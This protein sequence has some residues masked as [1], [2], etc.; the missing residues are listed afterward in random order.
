MY[1]SFFFNSIHWMKSSLLF[2]FLCVTIGTFS[3]ERKD[4]YVA[5]DYFYGNIIQHNSRVE[6]L[7]H[8]HP[9]GVM[10][11]YN[12]RTHGTKRWQ[13]EYG[14][15]D[16][17]VSLLYQDF[18]YDVLGKNYSVGVHY[19]FY[20]LNRKLQ[21]LLGQGLNYNTHPF[22][23]ETN[24]KN[25]A[26][27]SHINSS[28]QF[29]LQYGHPRI[30]DKF[31][32]R[33]GILFFH[34]SNG[35]AKSPNTGTNIITASI[36][37]TY[38]FIEEEIAHQEK[39]AYERLIEPVKYNFALRSGVNES[40]F[41]GLGQYPFVVFSAFADKRIS[42]K[43]TL[44]FGVDVIIAEFIKAHKEHVAA[45]FPGN[46][47]YLDADYK[48]VGVFV[49]HEFRFNKVAIPTQVAYYIYNPSKYDNVPYMR[50]GIKYYIS[51]KWFA[52]A[53]VRAHGLN[54]EAIEW[55]VGLRL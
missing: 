29:G 52:V 12:K 24:P 20:F 14:Y 41:V 51:E 27:G 9:T 19:N 8:A 15:P 3:Q 44:Q 1:F 26:Y 32:L 4:D 50:G 13:Q 39:V 37:V 34:H 40:N 10:L 38:D 17:G 46:T 49:G 36:G 7:V 54:A 5:F 43:N 42:Y 25:I 33:A 22:H 53:T 6:G 47:V 16:W 28:F 45:A 48:R 11:S 31:G 30:F 18:N 2:F 23:L 35:G 21:V 55:G